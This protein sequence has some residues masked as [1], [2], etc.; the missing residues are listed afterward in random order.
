MV[1]MVN[2][3]FRLIVVTL[4]VRTSLALVGHRKKVSSDVT[5]CGSDKIVY[6]NL[7][8]LIKKNG[9]RLKGKQ[10]VPRIKP[11]CNIQETWRR[12]QP[13]EPWIRREVCSSV[14]GMAWRRRSKADA[15]FTKRKLISWR[16][17]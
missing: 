3:L 15:S 17:Y 11:F 4:G 10:I 16:K 8:T 7:C 12:E 9:C 1:I 5:Q 13:P 2:L 14:D 6:E